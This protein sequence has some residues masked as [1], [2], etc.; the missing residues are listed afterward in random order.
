[1]VIESITMMLLGLVLAVVAASEPLTLREAAALAASGAPAVERARA[2]SEGAQAREASAR[3]L[4][5][6]SLFAEAGFLS[7]NNPVTAFSLA[8]EQKRFSAQEFFASDPNQPPFAEDWSGA[9]SAAWSI[10]VFGAARAGARAAGEAARAAELGSGRVR[11]GAVFRAIAAFS[12]ARRAEEAVALLRE[13]VSDAEKDLG[14]ARALAEEGLTTGADPARA[15]A[16]LAESRAELAGE[17]AELAGARAS[18]AALIGAE[19][20]SRPLAPLPEPSA[21][22]GEASSERADVA[23]AKAAASAAA[24]AGRAAAASRWPSLLV[25]ARYETH[26]PTPGGRYGT[27]AT[28]FAGVRVPLFASGAIDARVAEARA[29]ARAAGAAAMEADRAAQSDVIRARANAVAATARRQAF[30]EAEVAARQA[31]EI[32]QA[33]YA[34]GAARL[35][36][37][38]EAR[39]AELHA[40]MG[41]AGAWADAVVADANLRLALGLPPEGDKG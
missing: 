18:L 4:L 35:A 27:A 21:S 30:M 22:A 29:C 24:Q 9:L 40:R 39:A 23:A 37:L 34:E 6:P 41:A 33:R 31:R 8:L 15:R 14:I 16:A 3:S 26:A 28:V 20:A 17:E 11:D 32:Q 36:D 7:S 5:G 12:D 38:L 2:E 25:S 13:R 19:A 1:M 10:D